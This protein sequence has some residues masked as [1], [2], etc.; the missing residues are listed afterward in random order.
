MS[1]RLAQLE[2]WLLND[3]GVRILDKVVYPRYQMNYLAY[4]QS[5]P[6]TSSVDMTHMQYEN[7]YKLE[8]NTR[9]VEHWMS[10]DETLEHIRGMARKSTA[11]MAGLYYTESDYVANSRE[12]HRDLLHNNQMYRDS[13][14]EF[15]AMRAL[16]GED[17]GWPFI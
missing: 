10:T 1:D 2:K 11:S 16:L 15:Q 14:R 8:V 7:A 9:T 3:S 6:R 17:Q 5:S 4:M 12:R 13:W